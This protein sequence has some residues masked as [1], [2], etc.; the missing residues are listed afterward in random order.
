MNALLLLPST[1]ITEAE[2]AIRSSPLR[3][4]GRM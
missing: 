1:A 2:V 4:R 3:V